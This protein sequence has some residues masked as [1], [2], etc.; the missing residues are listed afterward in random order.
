[1]QAKPVERSWRGQ[2]P[3]G[4]SFKQPPFQVV[5]LVRFED[6]QYREHVR[7][8]QVLASQQS[9]RC[10]FGARGFPETGVVGAAHRQSLGALLVL[11][12]KP[13]KPI[14][15]GLERRQTP[16]QDRA[17]VG[18]FDVLRLK[19]EQPAVHFQTFFQSTG[20]FG[21]IFLIKTSQVQVG[22]GEARPGGDGYFEVGLRFS[23]VTLLSFDHTEQVTKT[24]VSRI[25]AQRAG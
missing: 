10:A 8:G 3:L 5:T 19:I 22:S 7:F 4:Q 13:G 6:R 25:S 21:R 1:M 11:G 20:V 24:G 23:I 17:L 18:R 14:E 9:R 2:L 16:E 15:R 12:R